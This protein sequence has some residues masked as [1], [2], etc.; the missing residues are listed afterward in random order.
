[1][2]KLIDK[3]FGNSFKVTT[4][5]K[6]ARVIYIV[7][8]YDRSKDIVSITPCI[9]T[10]PWEPFRKHCNKDKILI[11]KEGYKSKVV[12]FKYGIKTILKFIIFLSIIFGLYFYK[13]YPEGSIFPYLIISMFYSM[14]SDDIEVTLEKKD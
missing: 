9:L 1:M 12:K 4:F 3:I 10:I 14:G 6:G 7:D 5:P 2:K 13:D 11:E 8:P